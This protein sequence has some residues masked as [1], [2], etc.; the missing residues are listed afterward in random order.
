MQ[1]FTIPLKGIV[2]RGDIQYSTDG[3]CAELVNARLRDGAVVPVPPPVEEQVYGALYERIFVHR[4]SEFE[5]RLCVTSGGTSLVAYVRKLDESE[6]SFCEVF[7]ATEVSGKIRSLCFVGNIVCITADKEVLYAT[8][9]DGT[10]IFLGARPPFPEIA[11]YAEDIRYSSTSVVDGAYQMIRYEFLEGRIIPD[12][13]DTVEEYPNSLEGVTYMSRYLLREADKKGMCEA[14]TGEFA[15]YEAAQHSEGRFTHPVLVRYGLRMY[16]GDYILLS[17][18]VLVGGGDDNQIECEPYPSYYLS[19]VSNGAKHGTIDAVDFRP[20]IRSWCLRMRGGDLSQLK[21]WSDLITSVDIFVSP[22]LNRIR[23]DGYDWIRYRR[24]FDKY[25]RNVYFSGF[26]FPL[27][28]ED[29]VYLER[30]ASEGAFYRIKEIELM[31]NDSIGN[32]VISYEVMENLEQGIQLSDGDLSHHSV[33]AGFAYVFDS[34]LHLANLATHF[35]SG[36]PITCFRAGG[37]TMA[38]VEK[39]YIEVHIDTGE[40]VAKVFTSFGPFPFFE[41]TPY[42]SYP[43]ARAVKMIVRMSVLQNE[44]RSFLKY[45][46]DLLP[47][48]LLNLAYAL[49]KREPIG[50]QDFSAAPW[51]EPEMSGAV[52]YSPGKMRISETYNPFYFPASQ[53]Y[54]PTQSAI[55]A[56]CS[57]TA[58]I[59]QGQF[60]QYPLYIFSDDGIYA[61]NMGTNGTEYVSSQPVSREICSSRNGVLAVSDGVVFVSE[62]G[63]MAVV[64]AEVHCLSKSMESYAPVASPLPDTARRAVSAMLPALS[65]KLTHGEE[66]SFRVYLQGAKLGY[67]AREDEVIVVN[68]DYPFSYVYRLGDGCWWKFA[69]RFDG[70]TEGDPLV[71]AFRC[72]NAFTRVFDLNVDTLSVAEMAFVTR[73]VKLGSPAFKHLGQVFLRCAVHAGEHFLLLRDEALLLRGEALGFIDMAGFYVLGGVDGER[74][75]LAGRHEIRRN[76]RNLRATVVCRAYPYYLFVFAGKVRTDTCID[77]VELSASEAFGNRLR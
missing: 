27:N 29:E 56:V 68:R 41:L 69:E 37:D 40:S 19:N 25:F 28:E 76:L 3:E 50:L 55:V 36:F 15:R 33:S 60:G 77:G 24:K 8:F 10:Y 7:A 74:F 11:F 13:H 52:E 67:N 72:D 61:M 57:N 26:G 35:Y 32:E 75:V 70:F 34:K 51:Q 42:L 30:V 47:S 4:T 5:N 2:R 48:P 18:P 31:R 64:G 39:G 45:E 12:N 58:A 21:L 63:L 1:R 65:E 20:I 9:R 53:V 23:T 62:K 14:V 49:K 6:S 66:P 22:V 54:A 73:P 46:A 44:E 16:T 59:S 71:K 17:P 38:T 43:D